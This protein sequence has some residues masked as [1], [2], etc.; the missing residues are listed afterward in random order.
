MQA[1]SL[2]R[3]IWI[4]RDHE[5]AAWF[6][7]DHAGAQDAWHSPPAHHGGA[8]RGDQ[9][10]QREWGGQWGARHA[11]A[12]QGA[13]P[14][15]VDLGTRG[16]WEQPAAG[17]GVAGAPRRPLPRR[18]ARV[19]PHGVGSSTSAPRGWAR[20]DLAGG[21]D[22]KLSCAG[23]AAL[24][25]EPMSLQLRGGQ[26]EGLPLHGWPDRTLPGP[27]LRAFARSNGPLRR[28]AA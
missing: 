22:A 11:E 5:W 19:F 26:E 1:R 7:E 28:R 6:R 2:I 23:H 12:V 10:P 27:N 9:G 24:F 25:H 21:R 17:G 20:D 4:L 14:Y 13:A 3:C 16:R 18:I 15:R 8:H